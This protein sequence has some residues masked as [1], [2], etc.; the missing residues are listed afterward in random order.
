MHLCRG[1]FAGA[2][3][4]EGGYEPIADLLFNQIDV[5]G[6]FLEYDSPR[7]G[8]FEPLRHLPKGKIAVLGLVTT[9]SGAMET[10]DD[11]KRRIDQA[12][13]FA[14]LEQLALSPQCGFSS[15]IG[16]NAMDVDNEIAK[17]RLVVE[18]AREVWG[19]A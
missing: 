7:A 15:G 12:A 9:K 6:Y 13:K 8:G 19:T 11:L 1:N 3:I 2:W 18:T 16:G 10:K 17:L 4:A 14:P 5:D